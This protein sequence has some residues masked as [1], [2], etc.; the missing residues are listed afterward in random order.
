VKLFVWD[1][2]G[3]LEK[4]NERAVIDISNEVLESFG[5]EVRFAYDDAVT[6]YGRK[7]HEY[8]SWLLP[9][10]LKGRRME[11]QD[12]CFKLS[13][14]DTEIQC[15][16]LSVTDHAGEVLSTIAARHKQILISNTRAANLDIFLK[17]L[18][19][20]EFF[21]AGSAFAVDNHGDGAT[22]T[23]RSALQEYLSMNPDFDEIVFVGDS[24]SDMTLTEVAGG[25]T[26]LY[27]HPE[28]PFRN[29]EADFR[30]RDLRSVLS[31][32]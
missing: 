23:K 5:Y 10:E 4:G 14:V 3:T 1:L 8:F 9:T 32:I 28:F 16:W 20:E 6:L 18:A 7:W 24:P 13:E 22:Q 12:A 19:L 29:C 30:I 27:A 2:H 21:S 26:Y 11:L 25:T 15:R 17:T 31:Q